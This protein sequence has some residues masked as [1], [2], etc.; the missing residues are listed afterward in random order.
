MSQLR[1]N[2]RYFLEDRIRPN[3]EDST[4]SFIT[5]I[6]I[7]LYSILLGIKTFIPSTSPFESVFVYIDYTITFYFTIEIII[8]LL[9]LRRM[10][11]FFQDGWNIFDFVIVVT[12]IATVIIELIQHTHH[13]FALVARLFR[14]FRVFRILRIF[15]ALPDLRKIVISLITVIPSIINITLVLLIIFYIYAVMGSMMF[16]EADPKHWNNF[17]VSM[18]TLMKIL[19]FDDWFTDMEKLNNQ[20]PGAWIYF[21]SFIFFAAIIFFNFFVAIMI[22]KMQAREKAQHKKVEKAEQQD[23]AEIKEELLK[24]DDKIDQLLLEI[25]KMKEVNSKEESKI[26]YIVNAVQVLNKQLNHLK[27]EINDLELGKK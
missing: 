25:E 15:N 8:K 1:K 13:S 18:L 6:V 3:S 14:I 26:D 7:I 9:A 21:V 23:I 17:L 16:A 22:D 27:K 19:T 11:V 20:V 12:A 24:E 5:N 10:R 2:I 4:F